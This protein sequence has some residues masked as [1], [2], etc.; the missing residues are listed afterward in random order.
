[1]KPETS[2][3]VRSGVFGLIS[4]AIITL[5]LGFVLGG[6]TTAG[7][8]QKMIDEAVL[9]SRA[10]ICVAQFMGQP[11]HEEIL[12]EFEAIDY[13]NRAQ[14]IAKRGWDKMP[15]QQKASP[16]VAGACAE[17]LQALIKK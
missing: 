1:M 15:G 3:K 9:T 8:T 10:A 14:F 13:W 4:G 12:K 11:N 2:G 16:S 6:W 17:K 7:T 5:I